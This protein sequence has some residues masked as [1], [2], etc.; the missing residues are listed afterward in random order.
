[1]LLVGNGITVTVQ[2]ETN[3]GLDIRPP[4]PPCAFF[5]QGARY[6]VNDIISFDASTATVVMTMSVDTPYDVQAQYNNETCSRDV[7]LIIDAVT[8]DLVLGS[9]YQS[10]KAGYSYQRGTASS[11]TVITSQ[12]TQT[13]SGINKALE[14]SLDTITGSTYAAARNA[15]TDSIDIINT[16][17]EQGVVAAPAIT[18]PSGVNTTVNAGYVRDNIILNKEFIQRYLIR[19]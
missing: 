10:I 8:Y 11:S 4:Q 5:V 12:L 18:Y 16:V 19:L 2:G 1:M 3:S 14:L 7:G 15:L 17:I 13:V 9:N 6:Q